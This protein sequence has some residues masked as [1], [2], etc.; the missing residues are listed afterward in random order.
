MDSKEQNRE[1]E[2]DSPAK[3]ESILDALV[4]LR[5]LMVEEGYELEIPV[6]RDRPNPFEEEEEK[7]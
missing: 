6:R 1:Q 2:P 7:E 4:A 3:Q 5:S